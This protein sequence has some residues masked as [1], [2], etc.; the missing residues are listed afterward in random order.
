[1]GGGYRRGGMDGE[2]CGGEVGRAVK[3][4]GKGR[5]IGQREGG[6]SAVGVGDEE[7]EGGETE[8]ERSGGGEFLCLWEVK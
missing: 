6:E 5:G 8:G 2:G 1:M 4:E 3:G 7:G